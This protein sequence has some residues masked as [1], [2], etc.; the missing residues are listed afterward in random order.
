MDAEIYG[1]VWRSP[2]PQG[3]DDW[4]GRATISYSSDGQIAVSKEDLAGRG[5]E[6]YTL[7]EDADGHM[8]K[9]GSRTEYNDKAQPWRRYRVTG[10]DGGDTE[11]LL[12]STYYDSEGRQSYTRSEVDGINIAEYGYDEIGR[13]I[14]T[15]QPNGTYSTNA[16]DIEGRTVRTHSGIPSTWNPDP[17]SPYCAGS[18][19]GT[20]P[21]L[22]GIRTA[23][24]EAYVRYV[25]DPQTGRKLFEI[26]PNDAIGEATTAYVYDSEGRQKKII[27]NYI[28]GNYSVGAD[29]T[30][31]DIAYE[32]FYDKYGQRSAIQDAAGHYTWFQYDDFGR[33]F[34]KILDKDEDGVGFQPDGETPDP[35]DIYEVYAYDNA[36]GLLLSK[37][38]YDGGVI[39]YQYHPLTDRK[40]KETYP[41]GIEIDLEYDSQGRL[42]S[43]VEEKDGN[44]RTTALNY[45]PVTGH[46]SRIAKPEGTLNYTYNELGSLSRVHESA[47]SG[48]DYRYYYPGLF[49]RP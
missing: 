1:Q 21:F 22:A 49:T 19:A 20:D 3:V 13:N 8:Q 41:D 44:S 5:V 36:R 45:D 37:R 24:D 35:G 33:V 46:P 14:W 30:D 17:E 31:K 26:V 25:F 38:N 9:R 32:T 15:R 23:T 28:D 40:T 47:G 4:Q 34:R 7:V 18:L 6:S 29:G 48:V 16:Y 2:W 10:V 39:T 43:V 42:V 27:Y 11:T 12:S